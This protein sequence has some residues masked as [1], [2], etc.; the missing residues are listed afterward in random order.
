VALKII[1]AGVVAMLMAG[2]GYGFY[3]TIP[4]SV[5][6]MTSTISS[7]SFGTTTVTVEVANT[8]DAR[9]CGLSGR[10]GLADGSG[11]LFLFDTPGNYGFWMKDMLFDIDI[12]YIDASSTVVT[13]D[14]HV[15]AASYQLPKPTVFY[16]SAPVSYVLEVPAG[17]AK[18]HDIVE[19]MRAKFDK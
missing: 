2:I 19:G 7:I 14:S 4:T 13:V 17:Y 10:T 8:N 15:P 5:P 12:I 3:R 6:T 11:L 1:L 9:E 18:A 16:P